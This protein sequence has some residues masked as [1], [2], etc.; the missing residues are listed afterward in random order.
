[1][2]P[3]RTSSFPAVLEKVPA[4]PLSIV[5]TAIT[6]ALTVFTFAGGRNL[7]GSV[8]AAMSV[9]Q[10]LLTSMVVVNHRHMKK[11]NESAGP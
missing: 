11:K 8:L 6:V 10:I 3:N 9:G 5:M 2:E 1:M 7:A 4:V